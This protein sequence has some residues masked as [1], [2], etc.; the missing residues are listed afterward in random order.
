MGWCIATGTMSDTA[1]PQL[2]TQ[3][4]VIDCMQTIL[5]QGSVLITRVLPVSA[6][7]E[8]AEHCCALQPLDWRLS[9]R[10]SRNCI[11]VISGLSHFFKFFQGVKITLSLLTL[12]ILSN[13]NR[14]SACRA[15]QS[16]IQAECVHFAVSSRAKIYTTATTPRSKVQ[17]ACP[18]H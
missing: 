11:C 9:P 18:L 3:S 17:R 2:Q 15:Q 7:F 1:A 6:D 14:C 10:Q 16:P 4:M 8:L 13:C 12:V 5:M